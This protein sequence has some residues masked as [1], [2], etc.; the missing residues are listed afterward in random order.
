MKTVCFLGD[1]ITRRGYWLAEIFE[2][3]RK[4]GIVVWNC[5]VSGDSAAG[6]IHRVYADCL[7]RTPDTVVIMFGIN[8]VLR[9]PH[10]IGEKEESR[11]RNYTKSM[12]TLTEMLQKAGVDIIFCTPT[13][14]LDT[15]DGHDNDG[16]SRAADIV[17]ELA[18]EKDVPCVDFLS[19]LLPLAGKEYAML[20]DNVHPRPESHHYMAQFF[21]KE[22]GWINK[23][24]PTPFLPMNEQ[25]QARF[26]IDQKVREIY[27]LEWNQMIGERIKRKMTHADFLALA[28]ERL[29]T[30]KAEG[31]ETKIRWYT[32]F[33]E[34]FENK[35]EYEEE[36]VRRTME[37]A[38]I[39]NQF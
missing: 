3:L 17:Q 28:E 20:P 5:G 25:A 30:A 12:R 23:M 33:L 31:D 39:K 35:S 34:H 14:L 7:N 19:Y 11:L 13:P 37:M 27:F 15:G 8:D 29:N 6:A 38:N 1:S 2:H 18:R 21:M 22:L 9:T 32:F 4:Q 26:D 10:G 24:D 36:L 16:L